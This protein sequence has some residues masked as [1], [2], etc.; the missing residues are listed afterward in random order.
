VTSITELNNHPNGHNSETGFAGL[1]VGDGLAVALGG[2]VSEDVGIGI[3][4]S[5]LVIA[6]V[7]MTG[8]VPVTETKRSRTRACEEVV[9]SP[10]KRKFGV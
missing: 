1:G 4:V 7:G 3:L 2:G 8:S 6:I 5:A 9:S 10:K